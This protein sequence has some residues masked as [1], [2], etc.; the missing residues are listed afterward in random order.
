MGELSRGKQRADLAGVDEGLL[1]VRFRNVKGY[2]DSNIE[3][4][5]RLRCVCLVAQ[6]WRL[7]VV[8]APSPVRALSN[9]PQ[10]ILLCLC[11][12]LVTMPCELHD[13]LF[14]DDLVLK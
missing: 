13:E 9:L 1:S 10:K 11:W 14:G 2:Y 8:F 12:I 6:S 4:K 7:L 5:T 3:I